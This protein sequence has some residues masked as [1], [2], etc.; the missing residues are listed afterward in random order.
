MIP[1]G[2]LYKYYSSGDVGAW[3]K[4]CSLTMIEAMACG[5]PVIISDASGTP[6]RVSHGNGL[7]YHGEDHRDLQRKMEILRARFQN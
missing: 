6:E 1:H 3:P 2:E 4:Q 5:L 7:L